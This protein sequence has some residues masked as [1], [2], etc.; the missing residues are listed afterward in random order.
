MHKREDLDL[1]YFKNVLLKQREDLQQQI[2]KV[3]HEIETLASQGD[4]ND[5]EDLAALKIQNGRDLS[6][7]DSLKKQLEETDAALKRIEEGSYG[8]C[9]KTG[10][11]I[12]VERLKANPT[13]R[14]VVE[15]E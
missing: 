12:P 13:A 5:V 15:A 14:T 4:I 11:P 6:V 8:I 2:E 7:L 3:E 10:K 1:D 9:E